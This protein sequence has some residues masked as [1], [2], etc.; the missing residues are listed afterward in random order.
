[1]IRGDSHRGDVLQ[2]LQSLLTGRP[3]DFLYIDGDHRYEGVRTDFE[4][5][6]PL[7]RPG[8]VIAFHDIAT[9]DSGYGTGRLWAELRDL[10][11]S[12]EWVAS[13]S[14]KG[15]GLLYL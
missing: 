11:R 6:S 15:N 12:E 7:V 1:M 10:Y 14:T 8:G 4:M 2:E 13:S 9:R 3:I 5:Y